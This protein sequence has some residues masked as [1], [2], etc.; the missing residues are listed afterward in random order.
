MKI[1]RSPVHSC[2]F[3]QSAAT[4]KL[5]YD[6]KTGCFLCDI[7]HQSGSELNNKDVKVFCSF[8]LVS[9][10][11]LTAPQVDQ[12]TRESL[13]SPDGLSTPFSQEF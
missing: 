4:G 1:M 12:L 6:K 8:F 3:N 5:F 2:I 13:I 10:D 9:P 7:F 11:L